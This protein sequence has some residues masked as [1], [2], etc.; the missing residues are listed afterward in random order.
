MFTVQSMYQVLINNGQMFNHKLIWKLNLPLKI[1]IFLWY[2]VKGIIPTK[3]NLIET[4]WNG[5]KKCGFYNTDE[6]IQHLFIE[7]HFARHI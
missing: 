3:D 6:S 7:C 4:N 1:K 5:N 2:L